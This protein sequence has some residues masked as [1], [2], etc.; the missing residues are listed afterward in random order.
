MKKY[1][2]PVNFTVTYMVQVEAENKDGV[3]EMA[4]CKAIMLLQQDLE[5]GFLDEADFV[6]VIEE[7]I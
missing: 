3:P 5:A 4:H 7:P 6:G 1:T 2:V